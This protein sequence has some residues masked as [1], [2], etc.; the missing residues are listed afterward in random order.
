MVEREEELERKREKDLKGVCG[1]ASAHEHEVLH[2]DEVEEEG[3]GEGPDRGEVTEERERGEK[4]ERSP[5]IYERAVRDKEARAEVQKNTLPTPPLL[6]PQP[7]TASG[8]SPVVDARTCVRFFAAMGPREMGFC[9]IN[10]REFQSVFSQGAASTRSNSHIS[11]SSSSS[12]PTTTKATASPPSEDVF[13]SV[14][15]LDVEISNFFSS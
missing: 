2:V 10:G 4:V 11:S 5:E 6:L 15:E 13:M 7:V 8:E 14:A 3:R 9:E 1:V 12:S